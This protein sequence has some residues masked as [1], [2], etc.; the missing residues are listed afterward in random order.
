MTKPILLQ[1]LG[2]KSTE[3][4]NQTRHFA[5]RLRFGRRSQP[6]GFHRQN[7]AW[8]SSIGAIWDIIY[9]WYIYMIYIYDIYIWYIYIYDIY[10][11]D[12]Y[13]YMIYIY[14]WYMIYIYIWYIYYI[15]GIYY[16]IIYLLGYYNNLGYDILSHGL[17]VKAIVWAPET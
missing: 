12:I 5:G 3:Q 6:G 15:N 10:I 11:Y 14:I 7:L 9:I 2:K 8:K 4:A 1:R 17:F 13:I 16:D